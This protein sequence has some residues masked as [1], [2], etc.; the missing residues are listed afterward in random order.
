MTDTKECGHYQFFTGELCGAVAIF[1]RCKRILVTD[2]PLGA[3]AFQPW[4]I[5]VTMCPQQGDFTMLS[6]VILTALSATL[7]LSSASTSFA[8]SKKRP[9]PR[10]AATVSVPADPD[11]S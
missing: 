1:L 3:C 2:L 5:A 10:P 4:A 8:D 7:L 6:K 9:A 11:T